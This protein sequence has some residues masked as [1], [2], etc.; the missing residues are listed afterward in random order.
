MKIMS[1]PTPKKKVRRRRN[2]H[3]P[4]VKDFCRICSCSFKVQYGGQARQIGTENL[5]QPSKQKGWIGVVLAKKCKNMGLTLKQ[6]EGKSDQV[7]SACG[8]KIRALHQLYSFV[9]W[10]LYS[11][12]QETGVCGEERSKRCLRLSGGRGELGRACR[13]D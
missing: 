9:A 10:A 5:F 8:R 12:S 11:N 13:H 6:C 2:A 3:F 7:C 1:E 4:S